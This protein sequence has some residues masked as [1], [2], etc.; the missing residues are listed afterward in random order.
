MQTKHT[1][2]SLPIQ[3]NNTK[4]ADGNGP[5]T[6][7]N[8]N[9]CCQLCGKTQGCSHWSFQIDPKVAGNV[10][11]WATLTYCC[12]MHSSDENPITESGWTSD[13]PHVPIL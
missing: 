2:I 10:C 1:C 11:H 6:T 3:L 4:Y 7:P 12:W 9:G 13:T 8:A 5:R